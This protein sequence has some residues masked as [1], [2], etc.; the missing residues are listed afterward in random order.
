MKSSWEFAH[1][2]A[3][4]A[5]LAG[6]VIYLVPTPSGVPPGVMRAAGVIVVA[7]HLGGVRVG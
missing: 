5:C 1:A 2:V 6:A 3:A 7:A 4:L